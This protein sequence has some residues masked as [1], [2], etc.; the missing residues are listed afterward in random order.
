MEQ[1]LI[2]LYD[3]FT[4]GRM[5]RRDFMERMIKAAGG[6]AAATAALSLLESN[7]ALAQ[8]VAETDPGL[9]NT[10]RVDVPGVP[11]LKGYLSKPKGAGKHAAI[12]VIHENRGLNPHIEDIARRLAKQGYMALSLDYLGPKGGTPTDGTPEEAA[13]KGRDMIA[14]LT[15][16]EVNAYGRAAVAYLAKR[17]DST[18]KVGALGFC[19]GGQA[20]N[21]LATKEPNLAAGVVYYG[22]QAPLEDVPAIRAPLLINYAEMDA[23]I[24]AGIEAYDKA[25]KANGKVF[26]SYIYPGTQHAF[27]SDA[28]VARYSKAAADLAWSRTLGWFKKYLS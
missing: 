28:S 17:R 10:A 27:N 2:N 14:A 3:D 4:H 22:R 26:E 5:N 23:G 24:A 8:T 13:A 15:W 11:G 21:R 7:Y 19:W 16:D 18:G 25:L 20:V 9:E 12:V 6:A 1:R